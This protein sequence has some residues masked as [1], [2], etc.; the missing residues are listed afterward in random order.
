MSQKR[1]APVARLILNARKERRGLVHEER[2]MK[3]AVSRLMDL[4]NPETDRS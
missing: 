1:V 2:E 4:I 3:T